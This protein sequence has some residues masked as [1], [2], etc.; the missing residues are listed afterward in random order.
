MTRLRAEIIAI[1][2][3]LLTP[4]Y[5]DTNSLYL[6]EKLN[7]IGIEVRFKTIVGDSKEDIIQCIKH[8]LS[9]SQIIIACGGLGPTEDDITRECFS[10]A[11]N[12]KLVF[13]SEIEEKIRERFRKR[14][15]SMPS[16]C[17]KQAYILEGA[18]ILINEW[19]TAPGME[20]KEGEKFIFIL[21]GPPQELK[22]MFEKY[23][24]NELKKISKQFVCFKSIKITGL[25][26]SQT[27]S[28]IFDLYKNIENP[29]IHI[30]AY[31]GQ[32]VIHVLAYSNNDYKE[33]ESLV[34]NIIDKFKERLKDNIFSTDG[35][36]LE[37]VIGKL[38]KKRNETLAVA[39]SCTGG[40]LS[41][42]ITNV[43]GSSNYFERGFV[44][45][46]NKAKIENL[47]VSKDL[48]LKFGA[49]SKEVAEAMA[50]G[51]RRIA[52]TDYGLSITGIAGPT[53]GTPT[54]PVGLVFIGF[55][56]KNGVLV[57]RNQ[58]LGDRES[59][60]FQSTQKALDMLRRYL[61]HNK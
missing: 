29:K 20:I 43:S 8:A 33:A 37:E 35:E 40:Y 49:V 58:F 38:L 34:Q 28:L 10:K 61:I 39:E 16:I 52:K 44:T 42:R 21:P 9:R 3:E 32:I 30:L 26:E 31:P 4:Y 11:L 54:K 18:K 25:T 59:I 45:Y 13:F 15:L 36:E 46:S 22:P 55:A 48:I 47:G 60:K 57:T 53:G 12:K 14:G 2:S 51:I 27:E 5:V 41:H 6:T 19:G 17:K 1:G 24:F 7:S 56:W 50:V 23:I